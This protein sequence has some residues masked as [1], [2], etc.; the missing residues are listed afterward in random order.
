MQHFSI[1][2][3]LNESIFRHTSWATRRALVFDSLTRT[4]TRHKRLESFANCGS[5]ST[6]EQTT[7]DVRIRG[8]SCHHALCEP[9]R[10]ERAAKIRATLH[11]LCFGRTVRFLTLTLRHSQTP[12]SDQIDRLYRSFGTFRRRKSWT[13]NCVG[14]A[15]FL[16]VKL[17]STDGL[18]HPHLHILLEGQW[19]DSKEISKEWHAVTGDSSII[20]I[21]RPRVVEDVC[22]YA[23]GYCTKTVDAGI[24]LIPDKLDECVCALRGRRMCL[25]F[26]T[27]RGTPLEPDVPDDRVWATL[28]SIDIVLRRAA[29]GV[30]ACQQWLARAASKY[31]S[32]WELA[33][34]P[35]ID[36]G[37]DPP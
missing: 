37:T 17:S 36:D 28:G 15:A 11:A 34:P 13:E 30:V 29:D 35:S 14:G 31:K 5:C 22:R 12:L 21:T 24:W 7:D 6:C 20:D 25:T 1:P 8:S 2:I 9:C 27:W 16:E 19:W 23:V 18:W 10:Q 3:T 32:I 4:G 33:L 26:G